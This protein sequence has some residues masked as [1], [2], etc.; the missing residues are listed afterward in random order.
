MT[1]KIFARF[2]RFDKDIS[3]FTE[4]IFDIHL[5]IEGGKLKI[6]CPGYL[7]SMIKDSNP[8]RIEL[9]YRELDENGS[10]IDGE[11]IESLLNISE[12]SSRSLIA[13]D[14]NFEW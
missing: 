11:I 5:I 4:R 9:V 3:V 7:V 2:Y 12:L 8:E 14:F 10:L 1:T 6:K 13:M